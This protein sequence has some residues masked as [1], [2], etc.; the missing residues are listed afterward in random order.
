MANLL[1]ELRTHLIAQGIVRNPTVAGSLPTMWLEP[2]LG[3][4]APGERPPR[5]ADTQIGTSAVVGAFLT[6]GFAP[7]PYESFMRKPIVDLRLRTTTAL[8]AEQLE[9][10]ITAA[11]IDR[12]DFMLGALYVIEC[13]QWRA[14]QR[15]SSGP[16]GFEF[17][18]SYWLELL[19]P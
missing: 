19:R 5:G 17:V 15:L 16:Q 4:P 9:L 8:V 7:R 1:T 18:T 3:T 12:R 6:G 10:A 14:L 11:L 13:E 2:K